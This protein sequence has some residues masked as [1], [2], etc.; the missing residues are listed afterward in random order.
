MRSGLIDFVGAA[1]AIG[2]DPAHHWTA[3]E[4]VAMVPPPDAKAGSEYIWAG[5]NYLLLGLAIEHV[6]GGSLSAALRTGVLD[7][8]GAKR[9]LLQGAGT[10]TPKP[11][12][13][14]TAEHLGS[15]TVADLGAGGAISCISSA[16]FAP[17]SG[18]IA[19]DAP[20]LAAWTWHLFAGD[21]ISGPSLAAMLPGP[22][23]HGLGIDV[24]ARPLEDAIGL[25]AGKT[26]YG[27]VLAVRPADRTVAVVLVNDENF[28]IDPYIADLLD[29]AAGG[30]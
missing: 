13:L 22:D 21:V 29:L 14:P 6:T 5:P 3:A 26:G 10:E 2:A 23:G 24:L 28:R 18:G 11:W 27:T 8:V 7:P 4:L 9:V 25:T 12:A 19:S 16:S 30:G 15:F 17:G 1:D 20:S